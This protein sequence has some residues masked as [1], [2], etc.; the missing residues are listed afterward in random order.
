MTSGPL[1]RS[2]TEALAVLKLPDAPGFDGAFPHGVA[3]N[4]KQW[5]QAGEPVLPL[6]KLDDDA[7]MREDGE[8]DD[9][10]DPAV[11]LSCVFIAM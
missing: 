2:Q 11:R 5:Q 8:L 9:G 10:G 6:P 3:I 7:A 4:L 1:H